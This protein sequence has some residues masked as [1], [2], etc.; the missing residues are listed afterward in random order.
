MT[1][2]QNFRPH[3]P[4]L[5]CRI[6][7]SGCGTLQHDF[8]ESPR[9][10]PT[11][12][13]GPLTLEAHTT[14]A[15]ELFPLH[16]EALSPS[17]RTPRFNTA[18]VESRRPIRRT[19]LLSIACPLGTKS[20]ICRVICTYHEVKP[21][22]HLIQTLIPRV[23]QRA[24]RGIEAL[25]K[26]AMAYRVS[27]HSSIAPPSAAAATAAKRT[28]SRNSAQRTSNSVAGKLRKRPVDDQYLSI[29]APLPPTL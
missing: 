16:S 17:K 5:T 10:L 1:I 7:S 26:G 4:L 27:T 8:N 6:F 2:I 3:T 15:H 12:L 28:K 29:T 20:L 25:D 11:A 9:A 19:S 21:L 13:R 23:P 22:R 18:Y 14:R 24:T